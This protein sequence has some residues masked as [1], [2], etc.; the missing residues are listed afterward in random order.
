M[1]PARNVNMKYPRIIVTYLDKRNRF[2]NVASG[3]VSS[4]RRAPRTTSSYQCSSI[5]DFTTALEIITRQIFPSV[6]VLMLSEQYGAHWYK[7]PR[8]VNVSLKRMSLSLRPRKSSLTI[9]CNLN[10][11]IQLQPVNIYEQLTY[12]RDM[13]PPDI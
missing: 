11:N 12:S 5:L 9:S 2:A 4:Y 13:S 1:K 6:L 7:P 8:L 10:W 3:N